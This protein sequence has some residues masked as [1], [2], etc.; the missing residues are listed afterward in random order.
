M[1]QQRSTAAKV[2][3]NIKACERKSFDSAQHKHYLE[4]KKKDPTNKRIIKWEKYY[5]ET[6]FDSN[7]GKRKKY[8]KEPAPV[9]S[10]T[11]SAQD[12]NGSTLSSSASVLTE[13]DDDSKSTYT[14]QSKYI[15]YR[16]IYYGTQNYVDEASVKLSPPRKEHQGDNNHSSSSSI[17][18]RVLEENTINSMVSGEFNNFDGPFRNKEIIDGD[19]DHYC[20]T[21]FTRYR[22]QYE[23]KIR[24]EYYMAGMLRM[25]RKD[26]NGKRLRQE[27]FSDAIFDLSVNKMIYAVKGTGDLLDGS[28]LIRKRFNDPI[29]ADKTLEDMMIA[30][31]QKHS[32]NFKESD[33]NCFKNKRVSTIRA[34]MVQAAIPGVFQNMVYFLEGMTRGKEYLTKLRIN[35]NN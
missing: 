10:S 5:Q 19:V 30:M 4:L 6:Y 15:T 35:K 24:I 33:W 17:M 27:P 31:Y 23:D 16:R 18:D 20:L 1:R 25:V 8:N 2:N 26:K 11:Y 13:V 9:V 34:C 22:R 29:F 7:V 12:C 32:H 14:Y 21:A 28:H 3:Y